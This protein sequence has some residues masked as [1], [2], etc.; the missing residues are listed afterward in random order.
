MAVGWNPWHGCRKLSEG[1]RNCYVYRQDAVFDTDSSTARRTAAFGLPV[2]RR[3]DGRFRIPGG[4]TLYTCFTSDFLLEEADA[5][6]AE[7]WAMMRLRSDL[8][9]V[10]FTKRIGRLVQV[11]PPDWGAGYENVAIGCTVENRQAAQLRLPIFL[12]LPIRHKLIVC[13]PLLEPLDLTPWLSSRIEEVSA[14]GE[15]GPA[16]R[17]CDFE[18]VTA[19]RDQCVA[20][21]VPFTFHQ[22]GARLRKD[23]R[24]YRIPRCYQHAQ[25]RKAAVDYLPERILRSAKSETPSDTRPRSYPE[26]E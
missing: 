5:W 25:A 16:A 17:I 1:C 23:G 2:Q 24:I 12:E 7:A 3:R 15:S 4:E 21:G 11:L 10:F 20:A 18:W 19:L 9:F 26:A 22:T 6:R 13:A 14:G 8:K